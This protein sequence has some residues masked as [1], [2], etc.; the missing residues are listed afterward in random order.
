M[1][2]QSSNAHSLDDLNATEPTTTFGWG[3][4]EAPP[5]PNR[6]WKISESILRVFGHWWRSITR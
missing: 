3:M 5:T 2:T 1:M 6:P 4:P